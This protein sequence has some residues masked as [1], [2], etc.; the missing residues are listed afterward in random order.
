MYQ[1]FEDLDFYCLECLADNLPLQNLNNK[2]LDLTSKGID[3]PEEFNIK[4]IEPSLSQQTMINRI[5]ETIRGLGQEETTDFD[6][7]NEIETH[8]IKCNYYTTEQFN[9]E[10][11]NSV[12]HFSILHLNIHSLEFH[13]EELRVALKLIQHKF[14]FICITESKLHKNSEPKTDITIDGYQYPVG[15]PSEASKGGVLIYSKEG[16]DFRPR[17]DLTI[18]KSKELE[19]YFIESITHKGKNTLI[20]VIYRHPCMEQK[21]FIDDYMQPLNEKL[22][23]ENKN[24]YLAGDFNFN[25]LNTDKNETFDFFETMMSHKLQPAITIP[26]KINPKKSTI[27]DNIFTNQTN[28]DM[29]SGNLTLAISDHLPSFLIAPRDNQNHIPKK[30]NIYTRKTKNFDRNNFILD[31]LD[32][33]WN[34]TLRPDENNVNTSLQLFLTK[35]NELLD[36]YMP[37]RKLTKKEFK[38]RYKPWITDSIRS[39]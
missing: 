31:Y 11:L 2:Q 3:Y 33:D 8:P 1:N 6:K 7:E 27:I 12:K 9:K 10:K 13:I 22:Q 39:Y 23:H 21:E 20:G 26:T 14:D 28:P 38:R 37:I 15:T 19:S 5:E 35:M 29:L 25:L 30:Q 16:I 17:D 36:K 32:I 24:I 18:Y 34:S 4:D